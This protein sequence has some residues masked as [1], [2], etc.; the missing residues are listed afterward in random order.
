MNERTLSNVGNYGNLDCIG[1][2]RNKSK[3]WN[4]DNISKQKDKW[5][6]YYV[7]NTGN[8]SNNNDSMFK[9]YC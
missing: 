4:I 6:L 5:C 1:S 9:V 3:L 7:S 2:F 8:V